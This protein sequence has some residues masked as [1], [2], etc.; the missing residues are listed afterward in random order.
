MM[1]M[2]NNTTVLPT[3]T[4]TPT[5]S[6]NFDTPYVISD[7]QTSPDGKWKC[8][9]NGYGKTESINGTFHMYPQT[10]TSPSNTS[11]CYAS[12]IQVFKNFIL[13]IDIRTNKQLRQ[14]SPPYNWEV[15]WIFFR[16]SDAT[17]SYDFLLKNQGWQ[18]SKKDNYPTETDPEHEIF[19]AGGP[20]PSV[21]IGQWQHVNIKAV[22][23][24][25]TI[26]VDGLTVMDMTDPDVHY[27]EKM[28][29]GTIGMYC[30][31]S[32]V[33]FDNIKVTAI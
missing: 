12:S 11:A 17:H 24:R 2:K 13:D 31:D 1:K 30:E 22:D 32:D 18:F 19:P 8:V 27:P 20:I 29:Q 7:G 5:F 33:S 14:G 23:F 25:F 15:A 21:K 28:A 6:D 26:S 9:Y 4:P 16:T 3:P 10:V